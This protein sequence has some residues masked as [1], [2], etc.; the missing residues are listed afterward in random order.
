MEPVNA[1]PH[2]TLPTEQQIRLAIASWFRG[3]PSTSLLV[4]VLRR[5]MATLDES[6]DVAKRLSSSMADGFLHVL[7]DGV[8]ASSLELSRAVGHVS[9]TREEDEAKSPNPPI[10]SIEWHRRAAEKAQRNAWAENPY[11]NWKWEKPVKQRRGL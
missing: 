6:T 11:K 7:T 2:N 5:E 9:Q 10:G 8:I 1:G 3:G 4:S